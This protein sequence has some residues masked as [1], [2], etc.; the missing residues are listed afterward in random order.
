[1]ELARDLLLNRRRLFRGDARACLARV[2]PPVRFFGLE[3]FPL[4]GAN[5][6]TFN[7]YSRPGYNAWWSALAIA[8]QL[9]PEAHFIMT[10]ELTYPG[11]W[12]APVGKFISRW[13]LRRAAKVYG[14]TSM[15]PMPPREKDVAARARSVRE[16]LAYVEHTKN[17]L[18]CL[19]P[20]G[21]DMPGGR[22]TNPPRGA[23][24]FILQLAD[25]GLKVVPVGIWEEV[26]SLCVRFGPGYALSIPRGASPDVLDRTAAKTVMEKIALLLPPH[27]RGEFQ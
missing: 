3:V 8:S 27:L 5:L 19:A 22:L 12:Y 24:R 23:G 1:M 20:E 11:Q 16:V 2:E 6:V 9:Q 15:P 25:K 14:F 18:V 4:I 17:S 7:H 21:G 13:A 10:G 26:G